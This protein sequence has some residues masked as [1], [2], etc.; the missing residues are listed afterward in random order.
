MMDDMNES[1]GGVGLDQKREQ[2]TI[3]FPYNDLD[4]AVEV[5]KAIYNRSGLGSCDL[6]ELAA[7]LGQVVSGSFRLKIA[8]SRIFCLIEK[9]G[10]AGARLTDLGRQLMT[11]E[12]ERSARAESFLK[13]P[14]YSAI[15]ESYKGHLLP[16]PKALEREM[17]K[18][19]VSSKQTD[20]A[21]QV[22]ERSARQAGYFD[23]GDDRLV[24]PKSD[25]AVKKTDFQDGNQSQ[26]NISED[27]GKQFSKSNSA[28]LHPF[29]E[30]LLST[31][32][33]PGEDWTS[34]ERVKWLKTAANMFDL[35]YKG[36]TAEIEIRLGAEG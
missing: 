33:I 13:V 26:P 18:L 6:D 19:G 30:G 21:R 2:S 31:L 12:S 10:R 36:E 5:A 27:K 4:A 20:K 28:E 23:M 3:G 14:L 1:E 8:T 35:I 16:P 22:F 24:K 15:Y 25:S 29:I 7:E 11:S 34:K 17:Q 9:D 32:P